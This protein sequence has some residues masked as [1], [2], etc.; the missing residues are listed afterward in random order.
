LSINSVVGDLA[1]TTMYFAA[2]TSTSGGY[3]QNV[4]VF[5]SSTYM[6]VGGSYQV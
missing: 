4:A 1:S 5:G 2:S 6:N 3:A